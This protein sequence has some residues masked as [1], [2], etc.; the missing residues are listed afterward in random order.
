[1]HKNLEYSL[2]PR[3]NRQD[4]QDLI[5]KLRNKNISATY[6]G[7]VLTVLGYKPRIENGSRLVTLRFDQPPYVQGVGY[8]A[9]GP[10][11]IKQV[12]GELN[13]IMVHLDEGVQ[14]AMVTGRNTFLGPID[15]LELSELEKQ[16]SAPSISAEA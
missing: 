16:A 9:L 14:A 13:A 2:H 3:M 10:R 7:E 5:E 6:A 15:N 1:M 12:Q 11:K 4:Y 8:N